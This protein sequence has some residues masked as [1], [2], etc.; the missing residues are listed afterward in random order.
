MSGVVIGLSQAIPWPG[1]LKARSRIARLEADAIGL[2]VVSQEDNLVRLVTYYYY[3]YSYWVLARQILNS[4]L[5]VTQSIVDAA[6]IRYANGLGS[7]GDLLRAQTAQARLENR[8]LQI[9]QMR[10][11]ALSKLGQLT[12]NPKTIDVDLPAELPQVATPWIHTDSGISEVHNPLLAAASVRTDAAREKVSLA[13]ADYWP[14]FLVGFD[15]R[16]RKDIPGDPVEGTDFFS[17]RIGLRLPL[18][19][20]SRQKNED[21]AAQEALMAAGEEERAVRRRLE[22]S[23]TDVKFALL[24]IGKSIQRYDRDIIPSAKAALGAA[25]VAYEVGQVDFDGLLSSQLELLDVE[26][27]RLDLLKQ[28]HQRSSEQNQLVGTTL[29][30]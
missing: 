7:A 6:Q 12:D 3:E 22:Q 28:Y 29:E 11:S 16:I 8:K 9:E 10:R 23:L 24:T 27:E 15:Y 1:K 26:L 2:D 30:R 4:N 14:D 20:F 17:A 19:F 18:W 5:E 21:R 13:K 25:Q